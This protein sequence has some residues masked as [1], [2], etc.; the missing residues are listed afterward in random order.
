[1]YTR[2]CM[3]VAL[4]IALP[5]WSQATK[6][7][8]E[9]DAI[10]V[11]PASYQP[12]SVD[13]PEI[14]EIA[15][16]YE[17]PMVIPTSLKFEPFRS[18]DLRNYVRVGGTFITAYSDSVPANADYT[19][20]TSDVSYQ[21]QPWIALNRNSPRLYFVLNYRPGFT[22][23]QRTGNLNN[24][25]SQGV[26]LDFQ[27][28]LSPHITATLRD[29]FEK[30]SNGFNQLDSPTGGTAPGAPPI[31]V[32]APV[33]DQLKNSAD[34]EFTYQ[35]RRDSMMGAQGTFTNQTYSDPT[36]VP[37]LYDFASK[38]WCGFYNKR[39]A[40][41]HYV[42][43]TYRY[44]EFSAYG[45]SP[46]SEAKTHTAALFF[47]FYAKPSLSFFLSAGPQ[48]VEVV[49]SPSPTYRSWWPTGTASMDWKGQYSTLVVSYVRLVSGVQGLFGAF[50][51]SNANILASGRLTRTWSVEAR[52]GYAINKN[53]TSSLPLAG[54]GGHSIS[55]RIS[56]QHTFTQHVKA[57]LGYVQVYQSYPGIPLIAK[58]PD[59]NREFVS[60]TYQFDRPL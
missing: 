38:E 46:G 39:L 29:S 40:R 1:M 32:I 16:P 23:Y 12:A 58:A 26:A 54:P 13:K 8:S 44:S 10:P 3:A 42:G 19:N 47:A 53:V 51:S 43:T 45:A 52:G 60:L 2:V 18:D 33:A 56:F 21:I 17:I 22:F 4:L 48:H 30:T 24:Q 34:A 41:K 5:L 35:F 49:Q 14:D 7:E 15:T 20:V 36:Q 59:T 57:E 28:R 37:G 31:A 55:G 11:D 25:Q 50:D 9:P 6:S 27:Y